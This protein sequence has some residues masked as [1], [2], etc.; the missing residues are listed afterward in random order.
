MKHKDVVY[1]LVAAFAAVGEVLVHKHIKH[2]KHYLYTVAWTNDAQLCSISLV[3][4]G[5]WPTKLL[6]NKE[7]TSI[8]L[9]S[10]KIS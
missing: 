2:I 4:E 1:V 8:Q 5:C 10:F 7:L 6:R 9:Q 3:G